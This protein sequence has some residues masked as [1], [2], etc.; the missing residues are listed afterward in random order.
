MKIIGLTGG[1]ASGKNFVAFHFERLKIPVFDADAQVHNLLSNN[2]EIF[3]K[4]KNNFP[5]SIKNNKIDRKILGA[6]VL[7]DEKKLLKLE[8]IIYPILRK[9]EDEFIKTISIIISPKIQFERF[10]KRFKDKDENFIAK[11][12]QNITT[13]QMGNLQRKNRADFLIYNGLSKAFC[14]AQIK[15]FIVNS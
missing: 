6:E 4:I 2:E 8:K 13:K 1:V 15:N 11:M 14:F 3:L 5:N 10:K 9:K 7:M 12:F